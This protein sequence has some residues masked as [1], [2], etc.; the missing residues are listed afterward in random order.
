M[1]R[2]LSGVPH[3]LA[4]L[5]RTLAALALLAPLCALLW[6]VAPQATAQGEAAGEAEPADDSATDGTGDDTLGEIF[7]E[8]VDVDIVNIDVYVTDRDG[9]AITGLEADDFVVEVDGLAV[10]L[11]NFYAVTQGVPTTRGLGGPADAAPSADSQDAPRS[12]L[13]LPILG[14][15]PE[16]QKLWLVIYV[17]NFN[18][19]PLQRNRIMPA[20]R[21]FLGRTLRPGDHAML[22]SYDRTLKVRHPFTADVEQVW[23]ALDELEDDSGHADLRARERFDAL[24]QIDQ[25]RDVDRAMNYGR[26]YADQVMN[27]V[28][29]T[30]RALDEIVE[31]L[32]GLPGRKAVVYVSSGLPML[33]G[34][35]V[36]HAIGLKFDSS[37]AF[38]EIARYNTTRSF[39]RVTRQANTSRVVFYTLD[40]GGLRTSAMGAA[41]YDELQTPGLRMAMDSVI[42]ENGQASLRL[43]AEQTGG[44]AILN[45][46]D[47]LVA[48]N[49]AAQDF[50]NFYSLGITA[51]VAESGRWH[52]LKVRVLRDDVRVRHREGYRTR[53][54]DGRVTGSIRSALSYDFAHNP[55][56]IEIAT[57]RPRPQDDKQWLVPVQVK[58][59]L[60]DLVILPRPDGKWETSLQLFVGVIDDRGRM[61]EIDRVPLGLRL[62]EEH[63]DAAKKEAMV[64]THRLLTTEGPQKIAIGVVDTYGRQYAVLSTGV[65]VGG[66]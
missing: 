56:G 18:I 22:V 9:E 13:E 59:P 47:T 45:R 35:E 58:I 49:D 53:S 50:G 1:T 3:S 55:L 24:R 32:S 36:F 16:E 40:A 52:D 21:T 48:L 12:R 27:D 29:F 2:P 4:L 31:S 64:H 30:V 8:Q 61:S 6:L 46:N 63:V 39:E 38:S 23:A 26:N 60:R 37:E 11:T 14:E 62:A 15:V 33:A 57:A 54:L 10:P 17:D 44:R 7:M 66:A 65:R 34:E 5:L 41:E 43:M 20:L 25:L 42:V 28:T 19:E 51:S